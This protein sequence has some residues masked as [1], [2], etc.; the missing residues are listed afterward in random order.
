M[1]LRLGS[2]LLHFA[3][4]PQPATRTA[5]LDVVRA[6]ADAGEVVRA[7]LGAYTARNA[8]SSGTETR[9]AAFL[10]A[11][12]GSSEDTVAEVVV[13]AH[14]RLASAYHSIAVLILS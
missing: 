2:A 11:G 13:L 4:R 7:G 5:V 12:V 14:H 9:L 6:H 3:L 1:H 8:E 10:A